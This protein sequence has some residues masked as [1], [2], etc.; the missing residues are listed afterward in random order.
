MKAEAFIDKFN[1]IVYNIKI[2]Y[3]LKK[4]QD[5]VLFLAMLKCQENKNQ[6]T[7]HI[8]RIIFVYC[9]V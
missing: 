7:L 8:C 2:W 3:E 4:I 6:H 1:I 9:T 5:N